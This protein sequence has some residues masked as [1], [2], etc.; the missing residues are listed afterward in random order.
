M[1]GI[2]GIY[3]LAGEITPSQAILKKMADTI[4][5][6]G[7][8]DEGYHIDK[9]VGLGFRRLSIIDLGGGHQPISNED[10]SITLICN[11]EIYNYKALRQ[12]LQAERHVFKTQCD[13][14][15]LVHLYE[16]Q[17]ENLFK[18]LNGQ[19]AFAL[20]D[21]KRQ[22]LLLGRDHVGIAPLFYTVVDN[23]LIFG[24]EIKAILQ[25]PA[26]KR[27]VDLTGLDQMLTFPGLISPR[28]M[29]K[30]IHALKP[31]H[32]LV[33]E[34]GR[35]SVHEYWDLSYPSSDDINYQLRETDALEMLDE[36][37]RN[38][39][40]YRL[41]ADVPVGFYL[42]GGLDSSLIASLIHTLSPGEH[43]HSFS[44]GFAQQEIDERRYQRMMV[45]QVQSQHHET[46]FDWQAISERLPAIIYHAESPLKE[47]YN[48]CSLA[49]SQLVHEHDIR[50]V[51]TGEGA[52][53]LFAGYVG[54][55]FDQQRQ[56]EAEATDL[57][58]L[59]AQEL[60]EKL[61][62]DG[63]FFY[64]KNYHAFKDTK[65]A[66]YS[67]HLV[68][69]FDT[70]DCT[71]H[72][73]VDKSKL[74]GRHPLHKR[75]YL[76]FKFRLSDH[77]LADHG[78]RVAYANSVEARYPFLDVNVIAA[79]QKLPP[80][81]LLNGMLEKYILKQLS[82]RYLPEAVIKREKFSFVAPGSPYLLQ[83]NVPWI[84]DLLSYQRIKQDGYFN[85]DT[86][87]R[88]KK[89]YGAPGFTLSQTFDDDLLML[90]LTFNIFLDTFA[91][92]RMR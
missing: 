68:E 54:Y 48:T 84:N 90:V 20:F 7:P 69:Q 14:E 62:G 10:G 24:S 58:D 46:I 63:Q 64:E 88:L 47:S 65:T 13:I 67:Q 57:D 66:L 15:V 61:W 36:Q 72:P 32:Y 5:Y 38:A 6:R 71:Q 85:P 2:V 79:A 30:N 1:C 43:R 22:R 33:A 82:A 86:V 28:T 40:N 31:G 4:V 89:I 44:I 16:K 75:S 25:H 80:N 92:P 76:D 83:Q 59:L 51:L 26:V 12:C 55:R 3:H 53:E 56:T 29:F 8:D 91:L 87:E 9:G 50:V 60:Q 49:L 17:G 39:V 77:L 11:G 81:L 52:D 18:N 78:D 35:V 34:K 21:Q 45:A 23:T 41:N 74:Q 42:S 27:D 70:I 19:F 37:L 73:L